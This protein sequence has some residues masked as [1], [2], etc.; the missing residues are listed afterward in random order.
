L[1][2]AQDEVDVCVPVLTGDPRTNAAAVVGASKADKKLEALTDDQLLSKAVRQSLITLI[3]L[4]EEARRQSARLMATKPAELGVLV[5][6]LTVYLTAANEVGC[7]L[8]ERQDRERR[9]RGQGRGGGGRDALLRGAER[10]LPARYAIERGRGR[11]RGGR[12]ARPIIRP[13]EARAAARRDQ[14][15]APRAIVPRKPHEPC[16]ASNGGV[17][18]KLVPPTLRYPRRGPPNVRLP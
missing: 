8:L 14:E 3:E 10:G 4:L 16:V 5:N 1:D 13:G 7:Q 6:A 9:A 15:H 17:S 12:E 2:A 11:E 18:T